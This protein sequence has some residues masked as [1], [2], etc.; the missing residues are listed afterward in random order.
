MPEK[1]LGIDIGS[2][3]LKVVQ[4][5]RGFR[6]CQISGYASAELPQEADPA[7]IARTFADLIS[8]NNLESDHYLMAVG[9]QEAFLRGLSFPFSAERKI[10]QVIRFELEP[11]LP[12]GIDDVLVDFVKTKK[13]SDGT[14]RV[15]AAALPR[16]ILESLL[17]EFHE[18]GIESELVDLDGS[19]LSAVVSELRDYLPERVVI[20]DIGHRK[21]NMLYV[22]K[23][24]DIY[25]RALMFGCDHLA[26]RIA[27]VLGI[28]SEE[29]MASLRGLGL[30]EPG[31]AIDTERDQRTLT[32]E[33]GLLAREI[34]MS[35]LAAGI[36]GQQPWPELVLLCGGGSLIRG[37][38]SA[39]QRALETPVRRLE[40]LED[41]GLF[42]Q[43]GDQPSDPAVFSV[44]TGLALR[45]MNRKAGFNFRAEGLRS[46]SLL[47]KWRHQLSYGLVAGLLIAL[48][49][50]GSVG[51]EIY[52]KKQRV[53]RLESRMETVFR[54]AL[55]E[56]K[57]S[58]RPGQFTS[59]LE[60]RISELG[61][62]TVLFGADAKQYSTVEM[63]YDISRA[64]PKSLDVTINM[65][66][67][68]SQ[69]VRLSGRADG[70]NTVDSV[71]KRL[72]ASR[73][74][75]KVEITGA[76][77]AADGNGVQFSLE[78]LRRPL[79]GESS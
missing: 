56:F 5:I 79:S 43:V 68:D 52:A 30:A 11:I 41:L 38:A 1:I 36:Q 20:L 33:I 32:K 13:H 25:L 23:D 53:A 51:V 76:K 72:L 57:G 61:Q 27:T 22:H 73:N 42:G 28:S 17:P 77:A 75:A 7:Q 40:E 14:Q 49:W 47:V 63:L 3:S 21:T 62:S 78:L 55:P 15:I 37:L 69:Q 2:H 10:D 26:K 64:I 45:A 19:V 6:T 46:H 58:V 29:S 66:S 71:K 48:S 59:I 31:G 24:R 18:I 44:A 39:L 35:L 74:F 60:A 67:A 12:I 65:L 9:T 50:L 70:F 8:E 16:S 34:E 54:T 4:L